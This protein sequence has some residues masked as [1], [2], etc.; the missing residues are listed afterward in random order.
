MTLYIVGLLILS[1]VLKFH[2]QTVH[3]SMVGSEWRRRR[4][5]ISDMAFS[6]VGVILAYKMKTFDALQIPNSSTKK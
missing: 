2:N 4:G 6:G 3:Y 5:W 1:H